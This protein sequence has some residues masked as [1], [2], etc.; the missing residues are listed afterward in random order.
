MHEDARYRAR[1]RVEIFVRAPCSKVDVPI[2]QL[3]RNVP[4]SMRKIPADNT[5]L[6]KWSARLL[7]LRREATNL[8]PSSSCDLLDLKALA[9]V[10]LDAAEH[11][12]RDFGAALSYCIYYVFCT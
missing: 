4:D 5:S 9:C 6:Y 8:F 3:Q 2:V 1:T 7:D 11:D 10:E 12:E